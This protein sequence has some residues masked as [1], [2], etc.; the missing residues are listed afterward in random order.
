MRFPLTGGMQT[1]GTSMDYAA[2]KTHCTV[3]MSGASLLSFPC[4]LPQHRVTRPLLLWC[5]IRAKVGIWLLSQLAWILLG[6]LMM[7]PKHTDGK[8]ECQKNSVLSLGWI[9]SEPVARQ[10]KEVKKEKKGKGSW[11]GKKWGKEGGKVK[12]WWEG[13]QRLSSPGS[14]QLDRTLGDSE[15]YLREGREFASM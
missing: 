9:L 1:S 10:S 13:S 14:R 6:E 11:R 7:S 8:K 5:K 15:P 2:M 12:G 3:F 4:L